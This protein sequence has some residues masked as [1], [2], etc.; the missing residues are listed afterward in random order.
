[1]ANDSKYIFLSKTRYKLLLL[2]LTQFIKYWSNL[3]LAVKYLI[4]IAAKNYL[5][6]S[7]AVDIK[8]NITLLINDYYQ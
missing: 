8:F 7:T 3:M 1:M 4:Y 2:I 5:Y 6:N